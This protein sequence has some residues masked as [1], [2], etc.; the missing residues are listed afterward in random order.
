MLTEPIVGTFLSVGRTKDYAILIAL[1]SM[2]KEYADLGVIGY[3][4][5]NTS[6]GVI[7]VEGTQL[8][9]AIRATAALQE[10]LDSA[11]NPEKDP[12]TPD[13]IFN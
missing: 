6:T 5:L 4:V 2:S 13:D 8:Y 3:K 1:L 12:P 9:Q 7:E 11:R 10:A